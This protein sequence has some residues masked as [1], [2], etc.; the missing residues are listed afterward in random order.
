LN[1]GKKARKNQKLIFM[2]VDRGRPWHL[3]ALVIGNPAQKRKEQW[4]KK[5]RPDDTRR[6]WGRFSMQNWEKRGKVVANLV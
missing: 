4:Y 3:P 1:N 6:P 5:M 2:A